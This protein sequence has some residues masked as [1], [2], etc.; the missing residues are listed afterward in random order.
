MRYKK[1]QPMVWLL[2][3]VWFVSLLGQKL[4]YYDREVVW[5]IIY[6]LGAGSAFINCLISFRSRGENNEGE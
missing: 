2:V 3:T 4:V 5:I 1:W 6:T